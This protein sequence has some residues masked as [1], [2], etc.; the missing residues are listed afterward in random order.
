MKKIISLTFVLFTIIV[1]SSCKKEPGEGGTS[2][3]KGK[4]IT[5]DYQ[6]AFFPG[7]TFYV[8]YP[9]LEQDV[10]IIYGDGTTFD[11]RTRTS[12]DG[13]YEFNYLRKG[14]YQV[15]VY[16]DDTN[17]VA[18]APSGKVVVE[19]KVEI[20]KN[21]SDITVPDMMIIKL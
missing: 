15:F 1:I 3:I 7:S 13:S 2:S 4:I 12:F 9:E 19:Q 10:Y 16:S 8:E 5:R 18:P 21:K 14:S 6:G 20:T 17:F 11:N